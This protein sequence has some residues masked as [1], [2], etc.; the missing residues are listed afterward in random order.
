VPQGLLPI[1]IF[2]E[3]DLIDKQFDLALIEANGIQLELSS[4]GILGQPNLFAEVC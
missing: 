3:I 2:I 1:Q 4:L